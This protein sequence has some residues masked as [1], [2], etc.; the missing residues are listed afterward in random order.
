MGVLPIC[1]LT[2]RAPRPKPEGFSLCPKTL[3]E[4]LRNRRLELGLLQRDVAVRL[5]AHK[6]SVWLWEKGRA[7]PELK[8]IPAIVGFLGF[9]PSQ[10]PPLMPERLVW[11]RMG[12]GWS[13]KR[14][15]EELGVDPTTLSRWELGKKL[16][17]GV[18]LEKVAR[19]VDGT[20]GP[21]K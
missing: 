15:A 3:G 13:Q 11:F 7:A 9:N 17:R 1:H 5:G 21:V 2:I 10:E 16:P 6:A 4:H 14:L 20:A 12:K 18:Y 19:V 8:W